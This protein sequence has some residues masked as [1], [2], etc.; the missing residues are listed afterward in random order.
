MEEHQRICMVEIV[1]R[2]NT[3]WAERA[4]D[5]RGGGAAP[6]TVCSLAFE[7][8]ICT[9]YH[10]PDLLVQRGGLGVMPDRS[11]TRLQGG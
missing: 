6:D 10:S 9:T 4:A 1:G 2:L 5:A 7:F 11:V 3:R 8:L